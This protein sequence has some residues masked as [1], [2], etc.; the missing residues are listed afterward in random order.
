MTKVIVSDTNLTNIANAIRSKNGETKSYAI[1]E[2]ATAISSIS[3]GGSSSLEKTNISVTFE[4]D[5]YSDM[6]F[7]L[8]IPVWSEDG[9]LDMFQVASSGT[10]TIAKDQLA[11]SANA[12]DLLE[13]DFAFACDFHFQESVYSDPNVKILVEDNIGTYSLST[14][15]FTVSGETTIG[16]YSSQF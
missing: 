5:I 9:S 16:I 4:L 12:I 3:G 14:L 15:I 7:K 10:Y 13:T 2:M 8:Y 11:F 6:M 1:D